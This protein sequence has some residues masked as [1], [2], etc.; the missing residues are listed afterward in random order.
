MKVKERISELVNLLNRYSY[1]Y[2]VNDNPSISDA[3]YDSLLRELETLEKQ[4]PEYI[5]KDSP[6][7]RVGDEVSN[8]LEKVYFSKPMLSLGNAFNKEEILDFHKR[9][10]KAGFN[11]SYVCEL[12]I[13]GIATSI[14]YENGIYTL[15]AT[16]GNGLYG[17]NITANMKVIDAVPKVIK[18]NINI[19]LV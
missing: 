10:V 1:E 17:E 4:Y 2:Y 19:L 15:G 6:T 9:I 18:D 12:K 13:D 16:R 3:E 14:S 11:P 5:L 7:Q 8:K